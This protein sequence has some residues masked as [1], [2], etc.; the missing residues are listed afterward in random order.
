MRLDQTSSDEM[1]LLNVGEFDTESNL[2]INAVKAVL[3][4]L[5]QHLV[6][7]RIKSYVCWP[8]LMAFFF[9]FES[10]NPE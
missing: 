7:L 3:Y 9:H 4:R 2:W 5:A 1:K 10:N 8:Q 6:H